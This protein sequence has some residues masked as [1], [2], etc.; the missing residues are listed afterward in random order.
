MPEDSTKQ[1]SKNKK[2]KK[3]ISF[4]INAGLEALFLIL[5]LEFKTVS[6]SFL[7]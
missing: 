6:L 3:R 2:E 4:D 5:G 7:K 1:K